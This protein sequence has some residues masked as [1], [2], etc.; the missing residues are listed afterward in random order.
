MLTDSTVYNFYR[1]NS[2]NEKYTKR[3]EI[4]IE[5]R[6][7]HYDMDRCWLLRSPCVDYVRL[8]H[9]L[10]EGRFVLNFLFLRPPE[11][12]TRIITVELGTKI[13]GTPIRWTPI[14]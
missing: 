11:T 12:S 1:H 8:G 4:L 9:S 5:I 6:Y 3:E 7:L 10:R 14:E 2:T 13:P